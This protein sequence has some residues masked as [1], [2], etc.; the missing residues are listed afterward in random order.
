MCGPALCGHKVG[1]YWVYS[2]GSHVIWLLCCCL[3]SSALCNHYAAS[4]MCIHGQHSIV[5]WPYHLS[6]SVLPYSATASLWSLQTGPR[7]CEVQV[8]SRLAHVDTNFNEVGLLMVNVIFQ[9][10]PVS[11][12][13]A[14]YGFIAQA[15]LRIKSAA[16]RLKAFGTCFSHLIVVII[17]YETIIYMY[18]QSV[19]CWS[20]NQEDFVSLFYTIV[21]T[22]SNPVIY[23]M[24]NK[25]VKGAL[26]TLVKGN[27]LGSE[28]I[29]AV[30]TTWS[31]LFLAHR[32]LFKVL[33]SCT[34]P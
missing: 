24:R 18:L 3:L 17:F 13:F 10:V 34:T 12:I 2:P 25:D 29:S 27:D 30:G 16:G 28:K 4:I 20:K 14:S 22:L 8:L 21:T 26:R 5:Q 33:F 11:L 7:L 1:F 32:Q 31:R 9:I 23:T 19:K 15:V 6:N